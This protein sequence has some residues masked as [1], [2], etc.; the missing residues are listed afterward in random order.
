[1]MKAIKTMVAGAALSASLLPM[2]SALAKP[3]PPPPPP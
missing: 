2:T 1:M 3:P